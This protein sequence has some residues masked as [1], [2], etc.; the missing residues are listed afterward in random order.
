VSNKLLGEIVA[1]FKQHPTKPELG[2]VYRLGII[3]KREFSEDNKIFIYTIKWNE[4]PHFSLNYSING[5]AMVIQLRNN[6]FQRVLKQ[7]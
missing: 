3:T 1:D 6:Y 4:S 5:L 2:I 7:K